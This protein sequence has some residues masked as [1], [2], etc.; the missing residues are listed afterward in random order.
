MGVFVSQFFCI[1]LLTTFS[2]VN[3]NL[4]KSEKLLSPDKSVTLNINLKNG[5]IF[6]SILKNN[7][8][9]IQNS[10]LGIIA[11]K[12]DLS[13][14]FSIARVKRN[15]RKNSWTQVW[16]EQKRILDEHNELTVTVLSKTNNL[17]MT[18]HFRLFNDGL[19]FR[20]D[21]PKQKSIYNLQTYTKYSCYT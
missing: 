3:N 13:G 6:F 17:E 1:I 7:K 8:L 19:G 18:I 4:I 16:G 10:Q 12:F 11:D 21:I 5:M 2:C 9:I 15:N 20:Y 14:N